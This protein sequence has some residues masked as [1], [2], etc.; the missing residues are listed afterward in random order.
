MSWYL[1]VTKPRQENRAL[2]NLVK[3]K[4]ICFLPMITVEKSRSG[5]ITLSTEPLFSRYIFINLNSIDD[6]WAPIR[7]TLGVTGMVKFGDTFPSIPN[8]VVDEIEKF[9]NE[10]ERKLFK[11]GEEITIKTGPFKGHSVVFD[12]MDSES[13]AM[14]LLEMCH[15]IHRIS[16]S[17]KELTT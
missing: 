14:V 8:E 16:I 17:L 9:S 7:S 6:N 15:K 13:R 11:A 3:Q 10:K 2:E 12:S 5:R 4:Y 1:L